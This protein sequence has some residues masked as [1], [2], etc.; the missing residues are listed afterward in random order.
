[1]L[2][3]PTTIQGHEVCCGWYRLN[4]IVERNLIKLLSCRC[5]IRDRLNQVGLIRDRRHTSGLRETA[6]AK[7]VSNFIKLIDQGGFTNGISN[8]NSS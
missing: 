4:I 3:V 5:N 2:T 1:M 8:P 7:V 6:H